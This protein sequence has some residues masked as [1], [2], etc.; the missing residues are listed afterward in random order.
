MPQNYF[1]AVFVYCLNDANVGE[2]LR[3]PDPITRAQRLA[4]ITR[5]G[6]L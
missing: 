5:L 4:V 6:H 2:I 1:G 3:T